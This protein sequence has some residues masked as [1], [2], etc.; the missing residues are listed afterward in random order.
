[1][2]TREQ[3]N[4]NLDISRDYTNFVLQFPEIRGLNLLRKL[5]LY[6]WEK[7]IETLNSVKGYM[8]KSR[9]S[10][11]EET[12]KNFMN[13]YNDENINENKKKIIVKSKDSI[14]SVPISKYRR[15]FFNDD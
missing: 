10:L 5:R 15:G 11:F 8:D 3:L 12:I 6:G 9:I 14:K 7:V 2:K 4:Q 1:M 13:K